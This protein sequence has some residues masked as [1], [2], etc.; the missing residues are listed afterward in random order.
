M[1]RA[2]SN[3][4]KRGAVRHRTDHCVRNPVKMR[5]DLWKMHHIHF[6]NVAMRI[7]GKGTALV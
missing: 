1:W 6:K 7:L 2:N 4:F 3:N 5:L